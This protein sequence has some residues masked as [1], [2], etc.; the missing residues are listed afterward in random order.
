MLLNRITT[1]I[2]KRV[3]AREIG[4]TLWRI[5]D[6]RLPARL[7]LNGKT[8]PVL[9]PEERGVLVAFVELFFGDCYGLH[10]T[11]APVETVLDIGAN[12]GIFALAARQA[13]PNALI[14]SYEPNPHLEPYLKV[15]AEASGARYFMEAVELDNCHVTL[16]FQPDS[17]QTT[18]TVDES[19]TIP[20]VAFR[21]AIARLGGT[22]DFAKVDCEG[23]EWNLWRDTDAWKQVKQLATEYHIQEGHT[24]EEAHSVIT[25]LGF[26]VCEHIREDTFGLIRATRSASQN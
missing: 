22:V 12:V 17:V 20:A 9:F 26:T 4:V 13:F 8:V 23:A 14:H 5:Q 3:R 16:N 11:T 25:G 6:F 10:Q 7:R 24:H 1:F 18:S 19:S 2:Q 15:Q 21:E